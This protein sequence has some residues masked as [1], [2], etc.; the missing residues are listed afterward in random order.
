MMTD[1]Y[2]SMAAEE[3]DELQAYQ[4]DLAKEKETKIAQMEAAEA[5]H[6]KMLTAASSDLERMKRLDK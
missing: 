1:I 2:D 3:R 4:S 5:D 6:E